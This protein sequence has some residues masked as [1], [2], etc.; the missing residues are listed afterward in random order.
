MVGKMAQVLYRYTEDRN[1]CSFF[2]KQT[3]AEDYTLNEKE[4]V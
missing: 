1:M 4:L 2:M 3:N